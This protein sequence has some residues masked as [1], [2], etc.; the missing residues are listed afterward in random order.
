MSRNFEL[1]RSVRKEPEALEPVN[2]SVHLPARYPSPS[3]SA[4]EERAETSDWA[5]ILNV[6]RKHR[7][8]AILSAAVV[9]ATVALVTFLMRPIY[10]PEARIEVD[11]PGAELFK[12]DGGGAAANDTEY[13]ETQAQALQSD[14]LAVEVIRN[15]SLASNADI[16]NAK[17]LAK[18]K[19]EAP[20]QNTLNI[21]LTPAEHAALRAFTA[22]L[23]VKREPSSRL[24]T[25]AFAAHDPHL[26]ATITNTVLTTFITRSFEMRHQAAMQSTEWLSK[27]LDDIKKRMDA[28]NASLADFQRQTGIVDENMSTF[29]EQMVELNKQLTQAQADR[30]Q[31]EA[32]LDKVKSG[33][34]SLPQISADPVIQELTKNLAQ[35]RADYAQVLG[36]YGTNHPNAKRLEQQINELQAQLDKQRRNIMGDI[37]TSYA[38]AR[39]REGLMNNEMSGT[40]RK[41]SLMAQ[42]NAL[43]KEANANSELYNNL[44]AKIKEAG[45]AAA[46]KSSNVRVVDQAQ[47]LD[48]PTRP[49][50]MLNLAIGF[51]GALLVGFVVA[52]VREGV[53]TT[54]RTPEDIRRAI[55]YSPVSVVPVIGAHKNRY[56]YGGSKLL[57]RG[58][59]ELSQKFF[60]DNPQSPEAEALRGLHT[61]VRLARPGRP[62]KVLL[63]ASPFPGDG[64]TTVAANLAMALAQHGNTCLIDA[65]LRKSGV[66]ELFGVANR[67]GVAELLSGTVPV[68]EA[69][70][71]IE[72]VPALFIIPT[73]SIGANAGELIASSATLELIKTLREKFE[74]LVIDSPPI[75]PFADGRALAP[76]VDGVILVGRSGSTTRDAMVRAMELLDGVHSAPVVEI[77][78]NAADV[79]TSSYYKTYKTAKAK[80]S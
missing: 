58:A 60:I 38:A 44:Y 71:P 8:A 61:S 40:T 30:I 14:Q 26:A 67:A 4:A 51:I 45:I 32:Y 76:L 49:R 56:L 65:D 69:V 24:I 75:V 7:K 21:Q 80:A 35:S 78:L 68:D 57:S 41:L 62:P 29:T 48:L 27:Q 5:R 55:G 13:L 64:K 34:D 16:V 36:L 72:S 1:L 63:I 12:L 3:H 59:S 46:S 54:I 70:V 2:A 17:D 74:F 25:V 79:P 28:S 73:G 66:A 50:R 15:L 6:L 20:D 52:F 77:V 39:A 10:E 47:V 22:R 43:K 18:A 9:F 33:P 31:L 23:K 53:D 37:K 11:P 42:F 19:A